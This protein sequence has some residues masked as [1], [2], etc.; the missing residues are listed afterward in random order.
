MQNTK[1]I[2]EDLGMLCSLITAKAMD[3]EGRNVKAEITEVT[4]PGEAY[5]GLVIRDMDTPAGENQ[6]SPVLH[7][8]NY[9]S[10]YMQEV[11]RGIGKEA[12]MEAAAERAIQDY[13]EL[14][15]PTIRDETNFITKT[16]SNWKEL[17]DAVI[18]RAVGK[19]K[20][21]EYLKGK[22]HAVLGDICAIY[23]IECGGREPGETGFVP[24]TKKMAKEI[25]VSI[26]EMHE[27]AVNNTKERYP[28]KVAPVGA[29]LAGLAGT[30]PIPELDGSQEFPPLY[31]LTNNRMYDGA[32]CIFYP[33][34][35]EEVARV[36][37]EGGVILPSSRHELLAAPVDDNEGLKSMKEMVTEINSAMVEPWDQ[38]SDRPF[39]FD[40]RSKEFLPEFG[41]GAFKV[42]FHDG[43]QKEKTR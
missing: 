6:I 32:A 34:F 2:K 37:P 33:E 15:S 13:D 20:G 23:G 24:I 10:I 29:M 7:A 22:P 42:K 9:Y 31:V 41:E 38:L 27:A 28:I 39:V 17:K 18:L 14:D 4:H 25:G 30:D 16:I 12:A 40:A 43:T 21:K 35:K 19:R 26:K 3:E 36:L 1:F 8:D 5:V 11:D